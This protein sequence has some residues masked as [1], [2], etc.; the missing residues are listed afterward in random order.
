[1]TMNTN[2]MR[3]FME[4]DMDMVLMFA[5]IFVV[6]FS[7]WVQSTNT[8]DC[9]TLWDVHQKYMKYA[10][11]LGSLILGLVAYFIGLALRVG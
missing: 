6:M 2:V 4:I 7:A 3:I 1:M 5:G 9:K 10:I 8:A 11:T